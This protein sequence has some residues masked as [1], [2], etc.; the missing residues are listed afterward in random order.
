MY[1]YLSVSRAYPVV[2]GVA[3]TLARGIKWTPAAAVSGAK[4]VFLHRDI[5]DG[6][7][8]GTQTAWKKANPTESRLL[9]VKKMSR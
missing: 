1:D 7:L 4:S 8:G 3:P 6:G 9:V 2:R 5:V